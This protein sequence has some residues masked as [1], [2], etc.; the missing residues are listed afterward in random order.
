MTDFQ[1]RNEAHLEPAAFGRYAGL[2][3]AAAQL[4]ADL[5]ADFALPHRVVVC[6]VT[7]ELYIA[8]Q[9][10]HNVALTRLA[11]A[12][13]PAGSTATEL[14]TSLAEMTRNASTA[15]AR[16]YPICRATLLR[17]DTGALDLTFIPEVYDQYLHPT[18]RQLITVFAHTLASLAQYE[19]YP[20][21]LFAQA[22]CNMLDR[23]KMLP[24]ARRRR[25]AALAPGYSQHI[26]RLVSKALC[27]QAVVG[28]LPDEP[29]PSDVYQK[30]RADPASP[31]SS[32]QID[33]G[34]DFVTALLDAGGHPLL[35]QVLGRE[36]LYPTVSDLQ[37]PT[38]WL[39]RH[40][41]VVAEV[42]STDGRG[43]A[44]DG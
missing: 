18:G 27:G 6:A 24:E 42:T 35:R 19:A 43:T 7:P 29:Q 30:L 3:E 16:F 40:K 26:E 12:S 28:A 36:D 34:E 25:P 13:L 4:V 17:R 10:E 2:I 23:P 8:R 33:Q 15:A 5:I 38:Q 39:T 32:R 14:S 21:L 22:G 20:E 31:T 11:L 37:D 1:F 41:A 44:G 9:V